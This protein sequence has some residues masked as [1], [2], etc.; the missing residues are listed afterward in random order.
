MAI[1]RKSMFYSR[2]PLPDNDM[3]YDFISINL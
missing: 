1:L 2:I 3:K